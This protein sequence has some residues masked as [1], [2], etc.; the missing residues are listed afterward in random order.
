MNLTKTA[1]KAYFCPQCNSPSV[2]IAELVGGLCT[3]MDCRWKGVKDDLVVHVFQ[4]EL[5][6]NEEVIQQFAREFKGIIGRHFAGPLAQLLHKWGFFMS[7]PPQPTELTR[8]AVA[9]GKASIDAILKVR[10]EME[11]E[12]SSGRN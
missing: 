4:H 10:A 7:N 2:E 12:R 6:S 9:V 8:Y 1:D 3:C 5:G 11:K